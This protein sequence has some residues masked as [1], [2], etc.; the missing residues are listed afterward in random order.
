MWSQDSRALDDQLTCPSPSG[1]RAR[2]HLQVSFLTSGKKKS[3]GSTGHQ[4]ST[5]W[6]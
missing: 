6:K 4:E 3:P 2:T 1:T 5:K